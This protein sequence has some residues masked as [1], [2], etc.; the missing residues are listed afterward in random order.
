MVA[1]FISKGVSVFRTMHFVKT[2]TE[3]RK[4]VFFLSQAGSYIDSGHCDK[5][6]NDDHC[7]HDG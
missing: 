2:L 7:N 1:A 5:L 6:R 4:F 3:V